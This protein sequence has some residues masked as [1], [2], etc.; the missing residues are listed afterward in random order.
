MIR[1]ERKKHNLK[2]LKEDGRLPKYIVT[3][4]RYGLGIRDLRKTQIIELPKT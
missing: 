2:S 4:S 1:D 3:A